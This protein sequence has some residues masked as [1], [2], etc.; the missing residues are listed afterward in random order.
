VS[1]IYGGTSYNPQIKDLKNANIVVGTPGRVIDMMNK[2]HIETSNIAHFVL[3]EADK[4]IDMGF[5]DDMLVI[6]NKMPK[7]RQTLL[8][9]ATMPEKLKY[10]RKKFSKNAKSIVTSYKVDEEMLKQYYCEVP[11]PKKFSLLAHFIESESPG[12]SIVFCNA[13]READD[14]ARNL[15]DNGINTKSL[16]GGMH[17]NLREKT[18]KLFH[19]KKIDVLV[20]TDVAARGLD[21]KDVTHIFNYSIPANAEDYANRIGR[22]AR[23]GN[24]GIAISLL[25]RDDHDNFRRVQGTFSYDIEA[26]R[27]PKFRTL[28]FKKH[29]YGRS[30]G[31]GGRMPSQRRFSN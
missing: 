20:A 8:F 12:L 3:D 1:A 7:E 16:H 4:M 18:M 26:L 23:A 24:N 15:R 25:S 21:I 17:Q 5:F 6:A 28:Q 22:T 31:G 29:N 9:S 13:G 30:N 27:T 11:Y 14:V 10:L 19:S 2:G